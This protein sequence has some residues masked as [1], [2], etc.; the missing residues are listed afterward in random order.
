MNYYEC[1]NRPRAGKAV[2]FMPGSFCWCTLDLLVW[3]LTCWALI[4]GKQF[5]F[6]IF[7]WPHSTLRILSWIVH[8]TW[9][10]KFSSESPISLPVSLPAPPTHL[11]NSLYFC[12]PEHSY[13]DKALRQFWPDFCFL[14]FSTWQFFPLVL[15]KSCSPTES[16]SRAQSVSAGAQSCLTLCEPMDCSMPGLPVHHQLPKFTQTH[17]HQV[18]DAIQSSHPLSSPSLPALNLSQYQEL[19]KWASSSHQA[20]KL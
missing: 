2:I 1:V 9:N 10:T 15:V 16:P 5:L 17:V 4:Y 11:F 19:F 7:P 8:S 14:S 3:K 12:L 18:G 20:A 13:L 6:L